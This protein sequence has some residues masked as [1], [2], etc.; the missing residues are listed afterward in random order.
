MSFR[1]WI[2]EI[3][4]D[5]TPIKFEAPKDTPSHEHAYDIW[6]DSSSSPVAAIHIA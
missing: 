1:F 5:V 4:V 6:A 2:E 3:L